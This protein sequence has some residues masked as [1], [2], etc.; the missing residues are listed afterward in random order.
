MRK[1]AVFISAILT[2][3]ALVILYSVVSAY[4]DNKNIVTAEVQPVAT[5]EPEP[6]DVPTQTVLTPEEAA[7]LA[8]QVIGHDGL[9]SA[10]SANLNGM[11]AYLITFTN[12]DLVYVGMD[13]QILSVQ[14]APVVVSMAPAPPP[15]KKNRNNR[16]GGGGGDKN[17]DRDEHDD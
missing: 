8:V 13:G 9:L 1:S 3:F 2:T 10:E 11:D 14:V 4:R 16:N 5:L 7:Q 12:N 15:A 6:T 17:T